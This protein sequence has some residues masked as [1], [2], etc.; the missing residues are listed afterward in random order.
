M[1]VP[2]ILRPMAN[3]I[4]GTPGIEESNY[5]APD[6][7]TRT[8]AVVLFW[9]SEG[10]ETVIEHRAAH[11]LWLPSVTAR[12]YGARTGSSTP[13]E[14]AVIDDLLTLIVDRFRADLVQQVLPPAVDH[15]KVARIR[16]SLLL[17][18]AGHEYYG[19]EL[20]FDI[21]FH[22]RAVG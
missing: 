10:G 3:H 12:V 21:K 14:F 19:A 15:C 4:G 7:I 22:R 5:P 16:P 17:G 20:F 6:T 11:Q 8:P 1:D 9:G 18:Y 2:T 13:K